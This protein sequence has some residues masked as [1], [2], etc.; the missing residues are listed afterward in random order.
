[1][2]DAGDLAR[3]T[4]LLELMERGLTAERPRGDAAAEAGRAAE[5]PPGDWV[6]AYVLLFR[7]RF[8]E[9]LAAIA[10]ADDGSLPAAAAR[11]QIEA[12][13]TGTVSQSLRAPH[14]ATTLAG[15]MA[16]FQVSEAAHVVGRIDVSV[17]ILSVALAQRVPVRARVW[18][19]LALVRAL[20]FRGDLARASEELTRAAADAKA[21][22]ARRS[23]RC[24]RAL[25]DGFA[26]RHESVVAE[27][28]VLRREILPPQ[29]YADSGMALTGALGL[30][31][32][33]MV[34]AAG[35]LLRDG[36]GG[37]G[38]PLVPPALRGYG[39][40][41]LVEAALVAGNVDLAAWIMVDF[42][43]IDFGT[44]AQF[45]AAREAARARIEIAAGSAGR[46]RARAGR[47][48]HEAFAAGSGLVGAR[49]VAVAAHPDER[50]ASRALI[51]AWP[52][53]LR[54][55]LDRTTDAAGD[56]RL[57][58]RRAGD[59]AEWAQLTRSQQAVARLASQGMRNQE[60]AEALV[61]S[62]RT[63]EGHLRAIFDRL[64]VAGRLGI[65]RGRTPRD[66]DPTALAALTPRQAEI[67]RA[68]VAGESSAMLAERFGIGP[69]TVE[70]HLSGIYRALGV[71]GRAAAVARLVGEVG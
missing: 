51:D 55:W 15:A 38:L 22:Q 65:V 14:T 34:L 24:L 3:A 58:T 37:P 53:E 19:R 11:A 56:S 20:L 59:H 6:D 66:V 17:D 49:A 60:I 45:R 64:G 52:R 70:K 71:R 41:V 39:Y 2:S 40:D 48:A 23:V 10:A 42:D 8:T 54:A 57:R 5:A 67:A 4:A 43:R 47:A 29:T 46:G 16:T 13:C 50:A 18:L 7:G 44:N 69:K 30:A 33:G 62:P 31:N 25:V 35:E 9:A 1:M 28:A 12:L 63:V 32:A 36:G 27:V 21:P 68:L 26:G 61:L